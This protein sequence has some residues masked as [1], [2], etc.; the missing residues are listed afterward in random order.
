M[1]SKLKLNEIAEDLVQV[2]DKSE[3]DCS[4]FPDKFSYTNTVSINYLQK[5]TSD[6]SKI[7]Q[8]FVSEHDE[9]EE[10]VFKILEDGYYRVSHIIVPT[11]EWIESTSIEKIVKFEKVYFYMDGEIY[12]YN[13][14]NKQGVRV[15]PIILLGVCDLKTNIFYSEEDFVSIYNLKNCLIEFINNKFNNLKCDQSKD[16]LLNIRIKYLQMLYNV[17]DYNISC[18]NLLEAESLLEDFSQCYD[19]CKN[20]GTSKC[21]C[22]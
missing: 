17:L 13:F 4:V 12:E 7:K 10:T 19:I 15:D 21:N 22:I 14:R 3:Y 18:G 8:V 2:V 6:N 11:K 1:I 20:K 9:K 16:N 5:I